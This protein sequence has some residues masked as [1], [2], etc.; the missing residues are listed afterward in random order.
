MMNIQRLANRLHHLKVVSRWAVLGVDALI[1]LLSSFLVLYFIGSVIYPLS[2]NIK[3]YLCLI[4]LGVSIVI[5]YAL[6][7][8]RNVIRH[9]SAHSI[10]QIIAASFAKTACILAVAFLRLR[11]LPSAMLVV[12]AAGDILLTISLLIGFRASLITAYELALTQANTP[13]KNVLIYGI[14][15]DS[16]A[17]KQSLSKSSRFR[18]VG[19]V[20]PESY[21][22]NYKVSQLMVRY[23]AGAK[24]LI[25]FKKR[26][27]L[28]GII[29]PNNVAIQFESERL[30]S[31]AEQAGLRNFLAP[32]VDE[33]G[34]NF[35]REMVK[36]IQIEDLLGRRE[37][38]INMQAIN[39]KFEGKTIMVTGGAGSI[40]S[41]L[42]RQIVGFGV[43]KLIV[44]D[45]AETPLHN[46]RL[47][48]ENNYPELDFVPFIGDVRSTDRLSI[49]FKL[50]RP[51]VVFHAAAYKHVPLMEENP[52]EAARVNVT[53]TRLVAE[54]CVHYGVEKMVM[55]STD[56][57]VNPTNVMGASKR[58]AEIYVQ[59]LGLAIKQGKIMGRT[60]FIT[61]RFGNVLGSNGSVIPYFKQQIARGGPVTVTHPE[62]TRYFMTI[63]EACRLVMDAAAM[64]SGNEI[65]VFDMGTPVRITD[66][67][68]RMIR[69]AGFEP[70][71]DIA[72]KYTGL[73]PGE[74]LYEELLSDDENTLPTDHSSIRIARVRGYKF[75]DIID[76]FDLLDRLAIS[77][78][79][80]DTVRVMKEI[81]PEFRSNNSIYESMD[82]VEQI[83]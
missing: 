16:V 14:G 56:K 21:L 30:V 53:G 44:F 79:A 46:I 51:E 69:L 71:V 68:K 36:E 31:Y 35:G 4:S 77:A 25:N 75:E 39:A 23:F 82:K 52:C 74:K 3:A 47:E 1:S 20:N 48:L 63:P 5:F 76:K 28:E 50:Y 70:G 73:R 78:N 43:K 27:L 64:S 60:Q 7:V 61:T 12:F 9:F 17:I 42:C 41:E 33:V 15:V 38:E 2:G 24:E 49:A 58:L 37:I 83:A 29:Y 59:S 13:R 54:H 40:G 72:I 34:E 11:E 45:N 65:Y 57:A 8:Y 81:A 32:K 26:H 80:I 66:L 67:A 6:G 19:F 18:V 22:R 55:V 10:I 62:I